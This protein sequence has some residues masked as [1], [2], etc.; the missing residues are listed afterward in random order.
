[1]FAESLIPASAMLIAKD[2][3]KSTVLDPE[4]HGVAGEVR[5]E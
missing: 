2:W 5:S 4:V 1:M 3:R